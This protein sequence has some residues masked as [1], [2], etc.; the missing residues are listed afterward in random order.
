M[1]I[2][3]TQ[4]AFDA[5]CVEL[6]KQYDVTVTG[7]SGLVKH[8]GAEASFSFDG[9]TLDITILEKP[10]YVSTGYVEAQIEKFFAAPLATL[11]S[12]PVRTS[13]AAI[14][15]LVLCF[16]LT[17][18]TVK[19]QQNAK[20]VVA[21]IASYEPE[22]QTVVDTLGSTLAV[23]LPG[24]AAL[25]GVL[26]PAFD[27]DAQLLQ[28]ALNDYTATPN[29]GTL[30]SL[31]T[32]LQKVLADNADQFLAAAKISNPVSVASAK[33]AIGAVRTILLLMD[34]ALQT[35]L[36]ATIIHV[37]MQARTL[38]L[39]DVAPWLDKHEIQVATGY[40]A[41]WVIAYGEARGE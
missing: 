40:P 9:T 29:N 23:F 12:S 22:L 6:K 39:R 34:G 8:S 20:A 27:A 25:I 3:I 37:N 4:S 19:Q 18:C 16:T 35:V 17:G 2:L 38:K 24:D 7:R 11:G 32:A 41:S 5:A 1:K 33:L 10:F 26:L 36:P 31:N 21:K 14:I 28:A 30:L 13:V 15:A